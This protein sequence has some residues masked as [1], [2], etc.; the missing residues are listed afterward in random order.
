[1]TITH[2]IS[3]SVTGL[4]T[5]KSRSLL[6]I[7][8]IVIGITA[9]IMVMSLGQGAQD[10]I[11]GQIKSIGSKLIAI[12]P[13]RQPKGPSDFLSSFTD[14]LKE[15]DLDL[16][17]NHAN[18]PHA[19]RVVPLVFGSQ[20]ASYGV[21][22]FRPTIFGSSEDFAR[23]YDITAAEG[24]MFSDEEVK[25]YADV[26][27]I[28]SKVREELF[29][30]DDAV[31]ERVK[32]KDKT[33]RVIGVIAKTGQVSFLNFD[34][35]I[36]MP[37]TTAQQYL[38]GIRYFNRLAVEA[39]S[40]ENVLDTVED[41]KITLR[42]SHNITDPDKD[43]FF[44]QTQAEALQTVQSITTALTVF[45]AAIAAISLVVGGIGIMNIMLVSVTER[46]AE[47][48]LRKALGAT[49]RNIL[50]QFLLEAVLL[51]GVGGL[52]GITLGGTLS[53]LI[54]LLLKN[55]FGLDWHFSLP[56]SSVILGLSVSSGIGLIFGIYPARQA[57][58]K[59]PIEALRYE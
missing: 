42:N 35:A 12:V 45:L 21:N 50:S 18:V 46:T 17:R 58:K 53:F 15:R 51:T 25:G 6:T 3:T 32:I 56:I 44:I 22:T 13:G 26:V 57:A 38:F 11:L 40:D 24:R 9:I 14:S 19:D 29:G 37:Y 59:S 4:L 47:I 5:H 16:L 23:T 28:G 41:I 31:G 54:S 49:N 2:L 36:F 30:Q 7:L 8:G 10:L 1:M 27:V 20:A 55:G 48:G 39:D 43:D 52:I 33:Y 34:E